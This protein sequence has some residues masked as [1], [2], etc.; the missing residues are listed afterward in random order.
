MRYVA[1]LANEDDVAVVKGH[2]WMFSYV[3]SSPIVLRLTLVT[4]I[5]VDV[6]AIF[7]DTINVVCM[8]PMEE[9]HFVHLFLCVHLASLLERL[10]PCIV[11]LQCLG[12]ADVFNR[13]D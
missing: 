5:E 7:Q 2:L 9:Q 13:L 10:L 1:Y 8:R 4:W 6:E 3:D 11:L 12:V